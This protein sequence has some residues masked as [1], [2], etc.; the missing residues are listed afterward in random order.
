M[1][2]EKKKILVVDD[3]K[4]ILKSLKLVLEAEGYV[5][6]TAGTGGEAIVKSKNSYYDLALLDIRLPDTEGT[7]L[8]TRMDLGVPRMRVVMITGYPSLEN[9]IESLN[10]GADGYLIKPIDPTKLL[11]IIEEK[12]KE[13]EAER[14]E[15]E[16][17]EAIL[18][19]KTILKYYDPVQ[20]AP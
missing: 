4:A 8:L 20:S 14:Q 13:Q 12:L 18:R 1:E 10:Q 16:R 15:Y 6:A 9:T 7:E 5:V 2:R 17:K 3:D 19:T 11:K